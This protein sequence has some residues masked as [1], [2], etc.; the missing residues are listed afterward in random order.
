[1][2]LDEYLSTRTS[3]QCRV[4]GKSCLET[5]GMCLS[6]LQAPY[7][8]DVEFGL[9][10][11]GWSPYTGDDLPCLRCKDCNQGNPFF[12]LESISSQ[13]AGTMRPALL[14]G[15][16]HVLESQ[17]HIET[18][19]QSPPR[20]PKRH[21]PNPQTLKPQPAETCLMMKPRTSFSNRCKALQQPFLSL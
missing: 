15:L 1:M 13:S 21:K 17:V 9:V 5:A 10:F 4:L 8:E 6:S 12:L 11:V 20:T 3:A 14:V 2:S 19:S 7:L 16:K 18:Q